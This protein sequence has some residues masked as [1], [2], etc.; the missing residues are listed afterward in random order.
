MNWGKGGDIRQIKGEIDCIMNI[1]QIKYDISGITDQA[2]KQLYNAF[3]RKIR[4]AHERTFADTPEY[5]KPP[6]YV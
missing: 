2:L 1:I 5:F 3:T 6:I 4:L